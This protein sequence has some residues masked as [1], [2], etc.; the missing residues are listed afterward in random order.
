[1]APLFARLDKSKQW[2]L[3]ADPACG[4]RIAEVHDLEAEV[5]EIASAARLTDWQLYYIQFGEGWI[6]DGHVWAMGHLARERFRRGKEPTVR[7][8]W[9]FG[10]VGTIPALRVT[11]ITARCPICDR[12][13]Q[14]D[15]KRLGIACGRR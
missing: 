12:L 1:V 13:L 10:K 6:N 9:S 14:I 8:Q 15:P 5:H 3:C 2:V 4:T 11:R 7:R